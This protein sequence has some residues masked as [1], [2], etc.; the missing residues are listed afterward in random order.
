MRRTDGLEV[1]QRHEAR[2]DVVIEAA[3]MQ[4]VHR[5]LTIELADGDLR[6][7]SIEAVLLAA[8]LPGAV[9]AFGLPSREVPE[10]WRKFWKALKKP[11]R[12]ELS[13]LSER[14]WRAEE[15]EAALCVDAPGL[16]GMHHS[17]NAFAKKHGVPP[18]VRVYG[19]VRA[20]RSYALRDEARPF[21]QALLGS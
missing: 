6:V 2:A 7:G 12:Q 4:V 5:G 8:E 17:I 21:I 10:R 1:K 16:R 15:L 13:L 19:R 14:R 9:V 3:A 20:D 18:C 11:H